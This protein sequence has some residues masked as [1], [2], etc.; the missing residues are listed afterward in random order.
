LPELRCTIDHHVYATD[1]VARAPQPIEA[2]HLTSQHYLA[3]P[4]H[5]HFSSPQVVDVAREL[6]TFTTTYRVPWGLSIEDR[7]S[8]VDATQRGETSRQIGVRLGK[9]GSYIRHVRAKIARGRGQDTRSSGPLIEDET[10]R[11]PNEHRPGLPL[12]IPLDVDLAKLLGYYCAEGSVTSDKKRPNSHV[13]NFSFSPAESDKVEEVRRLLGQ[14]L[15][16]ESVTVR[17]STTLAVSASKASAALLLKTLC[18]GRANEKHVPFAL[19]DAPR[20]VVQSFLEAYIS[21]DGHRYA[22]GKVN[23]TT[24]S[25][26]LAYGI[27][28]LALKCG[29]LPSIYDSCMSEAGTVQG[30][31]VKRSPHQYS[32]VWYESKSIERR[33][34]ET[35]DYYLIPLHQIDFI[36]YTG[37]VYNMEVEEEHNYLAGFFLVSN[38]QNWLTSQ[39]LRDNNAGVAPQITTPQELVKVGQ[40]TGAQLFGSSYN[41]PLITSEWAVDVFKAANQ[42]GFR[43]V[44]ISNGNLT[45][46]VMDYIQ[47][48]IVGYKIDLKSMRDKNYR[49]LGAVMQNVLDG[50]QL[51]HDRGI[52]LE[53][54]TLVIPGF[55]DSNEE[56]WDAARYIASV[57]KNI[58][59]H[60][61]AFHKDYKMLDPENTDVKTLLRA[62]EIGQEAGLH[63]VYAG[64]LPGAVNRYENTYCPTCNELLIARVGYRILQNK[65]AGHGTCP[66]CGTQIPGIWK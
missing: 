42:A 54:V 36:D 45:T 46:Q 59:W 49:Q 8:I 17:R 38:C 47:P 57:S 61:T 65:L 41:E 29:W 64:N 37:D 2:R 58:P 1:D 10:I 52:W 53:V 20:S 39:T 62:A 14:C 48:H 23:S 3:I 60:V 27:A 44:Y 9:S 18:G 33:V 13:L 34:I 50:I 63:Y 4:R 28:W 24:V 15:R 35:D 40:R 25:R 11:F 51:V 19:F 66:K 22:N 16:I 21:G 31:A 7:Q 30:R 6:N 26:D 56:L 12:A 5:H 43:C 32:V 55:N